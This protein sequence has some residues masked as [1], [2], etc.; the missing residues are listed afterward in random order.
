MSFFLLSH[1]QPEWPFRVEGGEWM[2]ALN[3]S[4]AQQQASLWL[5][6]RER[7]RLASPGS[8]LWHPE[9]DKRGTCHFTGD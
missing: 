2:V 6:A 5:P 9:N 8:S 4:T 7:N 1:L 3:S